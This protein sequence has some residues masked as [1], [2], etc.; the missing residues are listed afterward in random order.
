MY[1]ETLSHYFSFSFGEQSKVQFLC[2]GPSV[3]VFQDLWEK[4]R[5]KGQPLLI[6]QKQ[7][8]NLMFPTREKKKEE[9]PVVYNAVATPRSQRPIVLLIIIS[10]PFCQWEPLEQGCH[11]T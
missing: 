5:K 6:P 9:E 1:I 3:W 7:K 10:G 11:V 2:I 8:E 4:E